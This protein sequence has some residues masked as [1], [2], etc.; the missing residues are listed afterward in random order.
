[1]N[2]HTYTYTRLERE[3]ET[4]STIKNFQNRGPFFAEF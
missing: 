2:A 1:M 4:K 3:Q